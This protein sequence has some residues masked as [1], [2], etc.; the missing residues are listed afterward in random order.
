MATSATAVVSIRVAPTLERLRELTVPVL[1][2]GLVGL[3]ADPLIAAESLKPGTLPSTI[4]RWVERV[5]SRAGYLAET[6]D[7]TSEVVLECGHPAPKIAVTELNLAP[8]PSLTDQLYA[9]GVWSRFIS[10]RR[11]W[12]MAFSPTLPA[13]IAANAACANPTLTVQ[14]GRWRTVRFAV[15][16]TDPIAAEVTGRALRSVLQPA[17]DIGQTPWQAEIVQAAGERGLGIRTGAAMT[18]ALE[19]SGPESHPDWHALRARMVRIAHLIDCPLTDAT[20]S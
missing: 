16:A 17:G 11:F 18:L 7:P 14:V 10:R 1:E 5:A 3:A 6:I 8:D 19:W 4:A 9:I 15:I 13:E 2:R 12:Q 20:P